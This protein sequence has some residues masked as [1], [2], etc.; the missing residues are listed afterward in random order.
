MARVAEAY[1]RLGQGVERLG[2]TVG[3][4]GRAKQEH[5][6]KK[7]LLGL[8][9]GKVKREEARYAL[10]APVRKVKRMKA[11]QE[12]ADFKRGQEPFNAM[13]LMKNW[14]RDKT[15]MKDIATNFQ[16]VFDGAF[17]PKTGQF[18][19]SS[20][21]P[22]TKREMSLPENQDRLAAML[23]S[24]VDPTKYSE[25]EAKAGVKAQEDL[26]MLKKTT[27]VMGLSA[28]EQPYQAAIQKGEEAKGRLKDTEGMMRQHLEQLQ[29]LRPQA[30]GN[31]ALES[32]MD[33]RIA[34]IQK[35]LAVKER[36]AYAE[37]HPTSLEAVIVRG[38]KGKTK[39]EALALKKEIAEA[40]R[41][42]VNVG[43]I[44]AKTTA[45]ITAK[46]KAFYLGPKSIP[47]AFD[48]AAKKYDKWDWQS[49]SEKKRTSEAME[50]LD[51][52]LKESYNSAT[53]TVIYG[54][55]S[56]TNILG[57]HLVDNK[58]KEERLLKTWVKR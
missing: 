42:V 48:T 56:T 19:K 6:Y 30:A 53:H 57:W 32:M 9:L 29:S 13:E 21:M 33:K 1:W 3:G 55:G 12:T 58:T 54:K 23:Y 28:W 14:S 47:W 39:E 38:M 11:E 8:E 50:I 40:G 24:S 2:T 49:L 45:Q 16:T 41:S 46:Q 22:L 44:A 5:E 26:T 34:S 43:D 17:D 37:T 18:T 10:D 35:K 31:K 52:S 27:G 51:A 15:A 4:I 36:Q 20:G 25:R 7:G